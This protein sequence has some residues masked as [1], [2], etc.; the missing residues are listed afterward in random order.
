MFASWFT[1]I[2]SH[3][4]NYVHIHVTLENGQKQGTTPKKKSLSWTVSQKLLQPKCCHSLTKRSSE[5]SDFPNST[6]LAILWNVSLVPKSGNGH[7]HLHNH[8]HSHIT[9][10]ND[11]QQG[12]T[13]KKSISFSGLFLTK[14]FIWSFRLCHLNIAG[15]FVKNVTA[16][17]TEQNVVHECAEKNKMEWK[18]TT[19]SVLCFGFVDFQPKI[20]KGEFLKQGINESEVAKKWTK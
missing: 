15:N 11:P 13:P 10:G 7:R 14:K 8:V 4:S 18:Q 17:Q 19:N 12:K 5:V 1:N 9:L 2:H 20:R 6:H 16:S 3:L